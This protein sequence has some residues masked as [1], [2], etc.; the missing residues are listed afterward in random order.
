MDVFIGAFFLSKRGIIDSV[1]HLDMV[2]RG[3]QLIMGLLPFTIGL[4]PEF[5]INLEVLVP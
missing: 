2:Y 5:L 3:K 4:S 1:P